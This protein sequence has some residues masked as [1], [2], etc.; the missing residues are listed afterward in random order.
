MIKIVIALQITNIKI[1]GS[2]LSNVW[3]ASLS[4]QIFHKRHNPLQHK[5]KTNITLSMAFTIAHATQKIL[6]ITQNHKL[7]FLMPRDRRISI[8][9]NQNIS[10]RVIH[11]LWLPLVC[12]KKITGSITITMLYNRHEFFLRCFSFFPSLTKSNGHK[13]K[14]HHSY[15]KGK[16]LYNRGTA[17]DW[18]YTVTRGR[19]CKGCGGGKRPL[20]STWLTHQFNITWFK[21]LGKGT[22]QFLPKNALW[23]LLRSSWQMLLLAGKLLQSLH[24]LGQLQISPPTQERIVPPQNCKPNGLKNWTPW[25]FHVSW[26]C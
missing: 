19:I 6:L 14:E 16:C 8:W 18:E 24:I 20:F 4:S 17:E 13:F 21:L 10:I 12:L 2:T 7:L 5:Q 25:S 9:T 1:R 26:C 11:P 22:V 15:Y 3:Q 23:F